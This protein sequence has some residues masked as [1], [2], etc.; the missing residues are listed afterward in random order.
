MRTSDKMDS[1]NSQ[2][3]LQILQTRVRAP[4][5]LTQMN[6]RSGGSRRNVQRSN[7]LRQNSR[8]H[9]RSWLNGWPGV[10]C[11]REQ[12]PSEWRN[13][14]IAA[15]GRSEGGPPV[16]HDW[17]STWTQAM[18]PHKTAKLRTV[19]TIASPDWGPKK[20]EPG[21]QMPQPYPRKL[22]PIAL[23]EVLMKLAESC[24]IEQH[25][26]R[27]LKGCEEVGVVKGV[28]LL[29]GE[30]RSVTTALK[31]LEEVQEEVQ[32]IKDG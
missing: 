8:A 27:L 21:Q 13:A 31:V 22:R 25:I 24:V 2:A 10:S 4:Q 18:V 30:V 1:C 29:S 26:D 6:T 14:D 28:H 5:L 12:G 32:E 15:I 3:A 7:K 9:Q 11:W 23:A 19:A 17:I 20:P 16:L